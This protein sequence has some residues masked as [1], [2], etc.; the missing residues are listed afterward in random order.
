MANIYTREGVWRQTEHSTALP[1]GDSRATAHGYAQL[2]NPL[3]LYLSG[4]NLIIS[5]GPT[6]RGQTRPTPRQTSATVP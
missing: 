3:S 4:T 1:D 6:R 5:A 2:A